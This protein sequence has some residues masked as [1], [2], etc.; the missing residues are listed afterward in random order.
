VIKTNYYLKT[1]FSEHFNPS[2]HSTQ[3]FDWIQNQQQNELYLNIHNIY[4]NI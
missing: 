3:R 1:F 4:N 2:I